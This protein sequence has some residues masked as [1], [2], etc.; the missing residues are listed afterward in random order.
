MVYKQSD[1]AWPA[2]LL[3]PLLT[4]CC[5][6]GDIETHSDSDGS[7]LKLLTGRVLAVR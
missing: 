6:S 7:I 5:C 3:Q 1:S 2:K 4:E